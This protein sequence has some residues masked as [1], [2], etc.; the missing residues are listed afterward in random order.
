MKGLKGFQYLKEKKNKPATIEIIRGFF[1]NLLKTFEKLF[2]NLSFVLYNSS[3]V[4]EKLTAIM[5][6]HARCQRR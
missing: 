1:S 5:E 2:D 3:I 4:I 6:N